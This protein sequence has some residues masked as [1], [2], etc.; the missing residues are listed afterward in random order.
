MEMVLLDW[1]RMGKGFCLAGAVTQGGTYRIVRP[2]LTKNRDQPER[3]MGWPGWLLE[4]RRRW[5]IFELIGAE[6]A[7][8]QP[9][10][11]EDIWVRAMRSRKRFAPPDQRRAILQATVVKPGESIFGCPLLPTSFA[12]YLPPGTGQRSLTTIIVPVDEVVFSFARRQ[13]APEPD[14]RVRLPVPPMGERLLIV[15]DPHLLLCAEGSGDDPAQRIAALG[16][17]LQ[18]MGNAVAVRLGL[19][20]AFQGDA[21][22]GT[23]MCWLMADGFFSS[24]DPQP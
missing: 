5:E 4:G 1:T 7:N 11:L 17:A 2:L 13:G 18:Q 24:T 20:R 21:K 14:I 3:N 15:K 23:A 10:H 8:P 6:P 22:Q 12:A 16:R 9:P 19:S